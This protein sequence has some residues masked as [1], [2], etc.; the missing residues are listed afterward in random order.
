MTTTASAHTS[1]RIQ[2]VM[3]FLMLIVGIVGTVSP[4]RLSNTSAPRKGD[5]AGAAERNHLTQMYAMREAALGAILL[6]GGGAKP[7]LAAT[8]G[9]TAVEVITGL[10][11]P[12]LD[13]RSRI[14]TAVT[15]ST[16]GAAAAYALS[17]AG[18]GGSR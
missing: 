2:G 15:A 13:R 11:S 12:A 16:F 10:G 4:Q 17:G 6:S 18:R 5:R 1:R 3:G 14:T 9:L 7:A 8:V